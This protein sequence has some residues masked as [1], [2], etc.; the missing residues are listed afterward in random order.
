MTTPDALLAIL[1]P[2]IGNFNRPMGVYGAIYLDVELA[3][4]PIHAKEIGDGEG[5]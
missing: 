2:W 3:V 4:A 5:V 1:L